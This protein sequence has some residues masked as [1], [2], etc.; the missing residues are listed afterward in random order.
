MA[1]TRFI[2][3]S[4]G[5]GVQKD[6]RGLFTD[7]ADFLQGYEHVMFDYNRVDSFANTLTV[8]S[9]HEQADLLEQQYID[10]RSKNPEATVDLLCHSQG[11]VVAGLAR[12]EGVRK[13]IFLAPPTRFL[14]TEAKIKQM[15]K[16][17]GTRIEDGTVIYPRRDGSTTII[18]QDYWLSRDKIT[19]PIA[20]Y[21]ELTHTSEVTIINAL[22]DETL[23]EAS[24]SMLSNQ[25]TLLNEE[26][27]HDFTGKARYILLKTVATI[28]A[29][30]DKT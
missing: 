20:L 3:Y 10:I 16:R 28:L 14:S 19:D 23:G 9:L 24:Y 30:H 12:L 8:T 15:L 18:K 21:N 7:I 26:A 27:D 2:L 1:S 22:D 5:F 25:V 11:C 4:H 17:I 13:T 29:Q 6:D